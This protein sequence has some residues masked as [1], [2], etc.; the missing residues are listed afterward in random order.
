MNLN[1]FKND[2]H[3]VITKISVGHRCASPEE[4]CPTVTTT[5]EQTISNVTPKGYTN[6]GVN[7][8][9]IIKMFPQQPVGIQE[10]GTSVSPEAPKGT[11]VR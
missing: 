10:P 5:V 2:E 6:E 3:E 8:D 4:I 11:V 7:S 1:E 9:P